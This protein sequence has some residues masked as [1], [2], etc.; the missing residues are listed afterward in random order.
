MKCKLPINIPQQCVTLEEFDFSDC[1]VTAPFVYSIFQVDMISMP[2]RSSLRLV[3]EIAALGHF[4]G[5]CL[6]YASICHYLMIKNL[7]LF[8][9]CILVQ[10]CVTIAF[11]KY[12]VQRS[13]GMLDILN[14]TF[15]GFFCSL[16]WGISNLFR[17]SLSKYSH[18]IQRSEISVSEVALLPKD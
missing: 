10:F 1:L 2:E 14:E 7:L 11:G 12:Q 3:A 8:L 9:Q 18:L 5:F 6:R 17:A 16:F 4:F 15:R 13:A